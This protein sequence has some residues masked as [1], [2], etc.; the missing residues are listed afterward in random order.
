MIRFA[1]PAFQKIYRAESNQAGRQ[2]VCKQC[3]AAVVIPN[4]PGR[5]IDY[6]DTLQQGEDS[7]AAQKDSPASNSAPTT[8]AKS[9]L[10]P[11]SDDGRDPP[12]RTPRPEPQDEDDEGLDDSPIRSRPSPRLG[13]LL[14]AALAIALV[15]VLIVA[16]KKQSG[17]G[18]AER[19]KEANTERVPDRWG[20]QLDDSN[21]RQAEDLSREI[22]F[23]VWSVLACYLFVFVVYVVVSILLAIWV[24]RDSRNRA[25]GFG[26]FWMLI[27]FPLNVIGLAIYLG[28]RPSGKLVGCEN[29]DNPRLSYLVF[30]PHCRI[31]FQ[32]RGGRF[33]ERD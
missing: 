31:D 25:E 1:C 24:I 26:F 32:P 15:I 23:R 5:E 14:L 9:P 8:S 33:Y 21:R 30:C 3:N 10:P 13:L 16:I 27:I 20:Q 22:A 17:S 28:S 6:S 18:G 29:C 7:D 19:V 4:Q 11:P 2:M 12:T